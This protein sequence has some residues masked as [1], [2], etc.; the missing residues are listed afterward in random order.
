MTTTAATPGK[1]PTAPGA[2]PV[3]GHVLPMIRDPLGL[4]AGLPE[5]GALVRLRFGPVQAFVICDPDLFHQAMRNPR[6]FDKGGM[7]YERMAYMTGYNIGTC[8]YSDHRRHRRL[9]QP[10]LRS[11]R[12]AGYTD[13]MATHIGALVAGWQDGETIDVQRTTMR[14]TISIA[15]ATM[16][17]T[18]LA[19]ELAETAIADLELLLTGLYGRMFLP[20]AVGRMP[21]PANRR[22]AR[23]VQR[24]RTVSESIIRERRDRPADQGDLLSMLLTAHDDPEAAQYAPMTDREISDQ[25]VGFFLAGA[26]TTANSL[27]WALSLLGRHPEIERDVADEARTVV[28][29]GPVRYEHVA[30]LTF[31]RQ[32]IIETLRMYSPAW[33]LTR[34]VTEDAELGGHRIPRGATVIVSPYLIHR[35]PDLFPHPDVFDP[36]RPELLDHHPRGSQVAFGAGPRK[37]M[38]EEFTMTLDPLALAAI[39]ARWSL[40]HIDSGPTSPAAALLLGPRGLRMTVHRRAGACRI[41]PVQHPSP[42]NGL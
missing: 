19:P 24:L 28:G 39:T 35:R 8:L 16:F 18:G 30:R 31:T 17:G 40:T 38:G 10:A 33:L 27:A 2:L 9:T 26:E 21:L 3:L 20:S 32:V 7:F 13:I 5:H 29:D 4:L 36:H 12:I 25:V 1:I 11:T 22:F 23:A 41:R 15:V 42:F 14:L 37:C 34:R 6:V